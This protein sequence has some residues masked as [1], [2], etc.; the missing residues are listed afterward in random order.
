MA[1][2]RILEYGV[3]SAEWDGAKAVNHAQGTEA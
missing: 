1:S 3:Q 2:L